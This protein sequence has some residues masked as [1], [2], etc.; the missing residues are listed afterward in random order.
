MSIQSYDDEFRYAP[1]VEQQ[2]PEIEAM[3]SNRFDDSLIPSDAR[4]EL[5]RLK[6]ENT[7]ARSRY[8]FSMQD[9]FKLERQGQILTSNEFLRRLRT[10]GL[11]VWY[12]DRSGMAGTT[13]LYAVVPGW[14][15]AEQQ[16]VGFVQLP[17]MQEFEELHF[18]RY[19][20]PLGCKRRG[21]RTVLLRLVQN[22]IISEEK[23]NQ[24]FR[25]APTG[26]VSRRYLQQMHHF[27]NRDI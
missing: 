25:E 9:E 16:Y 17:F 10:I 7:Y 26:P 6:E 2:I 11:H 21:W 20:V 23:L 3:M 14:L 27:R 4:E 8:K 24:V 15:G 18:D 1:E 12:G 5:A 13:G 19:D 22:R